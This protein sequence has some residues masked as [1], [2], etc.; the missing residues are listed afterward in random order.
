MG[1]VFGARCTVERLLILVLAMEGRAFLVLPQTGIAA[2]PRMKRENWDFQD[3]LCMYYSSCCSAWEI[4]L[5][6]HK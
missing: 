6:Q 3:V 2:S 5:L 1:V 4:G